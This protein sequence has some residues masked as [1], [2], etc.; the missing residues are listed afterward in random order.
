MAFC[1]Q[2]A[3]SFLVL[4]TD[5]DSFEITAKGVEDAKDT[6]EKNLR[7]YLQENTVPFPDYYGSFFFGDVEIS[8]TDMRMGNVSWSELELKISQSDSTLQLKM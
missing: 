4:C 7:L 3:I 8:L 5:S 6:A 2:I 1:F